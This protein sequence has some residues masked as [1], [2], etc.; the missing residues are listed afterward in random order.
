VPRWAHKGKLCGCFGL[1]WAI[2]L[3]LGIECE[4]GPLL[5]KAASLLSLLLHAAA[6]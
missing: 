3:K 6:G 2:V 5:L 4:P 1:A